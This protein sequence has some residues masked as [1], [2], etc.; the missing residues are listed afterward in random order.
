L[1]LILSS[2]VLFFTSFLQFDLLGWIY[3]IG[4]LVITKIS[5]LKLKIVNYRKIII[6]NQSINKIM[7]NNNRKLVNDLNNKWKLVKVSNR[8]NK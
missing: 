3:K 4:K 2:Y 7:K 6:I 5:L 1:I 8:F